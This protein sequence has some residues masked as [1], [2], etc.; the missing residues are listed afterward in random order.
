MQRPGTSPTFTCWWNPDRE[1]KPSLERLS[2]LQAMLE[3]R[4][5]AYRP[6][7]VEAMAMEVDYFA[8]CARLQSQ[9]GVYLL[10]RPKDFKQADEVVGLLQNHWKQNGII[11]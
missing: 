6:S 11:A 4:A 5:N 1:E 8:V 7:L 9:A 2:P 3:L 10:R